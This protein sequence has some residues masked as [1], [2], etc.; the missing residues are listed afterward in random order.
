MPTSVENVVTFMGCLGEAMATMDAVPACVSRFV[1]ENLVYVLDFRTLPYQVTQG[2]IAAKM[3][4]IMI[5]CDCPFVH[6]VC[7]YAFLCM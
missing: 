2:A 4:A 6:P 5:R 7:A 3:G 1:I